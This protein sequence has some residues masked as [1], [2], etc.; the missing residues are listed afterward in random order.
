MS[1]YTTVR[2]LIDSAVRSTEG[3][4]FF[5]A[6][7]SYKEVYNQ[8]SSSNNEQLNEDGLIS[9]DLSSLAEDVQFQDIEYNYDSPET[10]GKS[11]SEVSVPFTGSEL[12]LMSN[13]SVESQYS[14]LD[15]RSSEIRLPKEHKREQFYKRFSSEY[16][17]PKGQ[18]LDF[19]L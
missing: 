17:L 18:A 7:V 2:S 8:I 11:F 3:V 19:T 9:D 14:I 4:Q 10:P 5:Q 15:K 1:I 16:K 12:S 13:I 6:Y